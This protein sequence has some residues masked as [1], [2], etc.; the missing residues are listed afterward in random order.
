M[1]YHR[2]SCWFLS[3][4]NDQPE[5]GIIFL[6]KFSFFLQACTYKTWNKTL[7]KWFCYMLCQLFW[8]LVPMLCNNILYVNGL[9]STS[10]FLRLRLC[11]LLIFYTN[12]IPFHSLLRAISGTKSILYCFYDLKLSQYKL[13]SNRFNGL[14]YRAP[15]PPMAQQ[16][17]KRL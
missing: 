1:S 5:Q 14:T 13:H 15:G 11:K 10:F 6:K 16:I 8:I 17:H 9:L 4:G 2:L 3:I 7:K 12:C